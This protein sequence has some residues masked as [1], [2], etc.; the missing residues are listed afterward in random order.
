[1]KLVKNVLKVFLVFIFIIIPT[2]LILY[3]MFIDFL[4]CYVMVN[5][6]DTKLELLLN[7][8]GLNADEVKFIFLDTNAGDGY[9][10]TVI[11]K[12]LSIDDNSWNYY[13]D[14][15]NYMKENGID[16]YDTLN[17]LTYIYIQRLKYYMRR[18]TMGTI[19]LLTQPHK[20]EKIV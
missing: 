19:Y 14:L 1:M 20:K 16:V 6:N 4:G 10:I 11:N 17:K 5:N 3:N 7:N 15:E 12:N 13:I 8:C 9:H 2:I 18:N